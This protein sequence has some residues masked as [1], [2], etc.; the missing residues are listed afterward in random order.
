M[1]RRRALS[2]LSHVFVFSLLLSVLVTVTMGQANVQ[3]QWST[4][5]YVVP[6]NPVHAALLYNGKVLMVAGSGNCPPAQSGCPSGA[7]YGPANGSGAAIWD[8]AAGNITQFTLAWD[9]FCNA[10]AVLPDGRAFINGGTIQYDPFYG[11]LRSSVFDPSTNTFTDVQSMAHGRWYPTVTTLGD[12]RIMTF[13]G[14]SETGG[15]NTAV[16]FY[17]AGRNGPPPESRSVASSARR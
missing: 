9:M 12:G 1:N 16:E 2:C 15:T 10:V 3:G 13:S 6:I 5:P 8:P 4:L 7:P 11:E 17:T 14:L